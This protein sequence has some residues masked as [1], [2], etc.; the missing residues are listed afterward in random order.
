MRSRYDLQILKAIGKTEYADTMAIKKELEMIK[1]KKKLHSAA[2]S[3]T[4]QVG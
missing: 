4:M 1:S 3:K 2:V